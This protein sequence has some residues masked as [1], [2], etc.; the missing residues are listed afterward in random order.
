MQESA[1]YPQRPASTSLYSLHRRSRIVVTTILSLLTA[2]MV[3]GSLFWIQWAGQRSTALRYPFPQ[4][5]MELSSSAPFVR[6]QSY[7]FSAMASG[8][9]LSYAWDFGDQSTGAGT[10]A[11]HAYQTVGNFTV[12][13]IVTDPAGHY[14]TRST[15]IAVVPTAPQASFTFSY[16]YYAGYIYFDASGSVADSSTTLATYE[17]D[18]GDGSTDTRNYYQENHA[19]TS[20]GAY[21]V[22]LVVVDATG[23]RSSPYLLSV[24]IS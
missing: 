5:Q 1:F 17:W 4:V 6:T 9:E 23:Q 18:F 21:Q 24:N 15:T 8:R 16:S 20:I 14:V 3:V 11:N 19:Y 10:I 7:Q 13:L 2:V 22:S 12:T